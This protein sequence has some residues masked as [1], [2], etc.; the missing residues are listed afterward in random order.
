M[1]RLL[2]EI[3]KRGCATLRLNNPEQHNAFDDR[4]I[5]DLTAA[6]QQLAE[7]QQVRVVTLCSSGKSFSAGADLNWMRRMA[8]YSREENLQDALALAELMKTLNELPKPTIALVQGA[9]FGGGVG[10]VAACDIAIASAQAQFCLSEVKLGLIPATISPYVLAA[11]GERAARR[12]FLSAERFTADEALR[13]G[14]LHQVVEAEQ[15]EPTGAAI[16]Q[17]LL[18]NGPQAL[19]EAK[20]LIRDVVNRPLTAELQ[21]ITAER[22]AAIRASDEGRE[23]LNAFLQKH[24]P[25][26]TEDLDDV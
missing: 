23:G 7:D 24:K 5:T 22:I 25:Y 2:T 18:Q 6:L 21:K 8:D 1:Q 4:L 15:L 9:T 3:D 26:W 13:I 10:L 19:T 14:L 11:I 16:C 17:Q 12:Y 20:R